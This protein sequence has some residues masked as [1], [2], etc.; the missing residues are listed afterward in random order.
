MGIRVVI[1]G[2]GVIGACLAYYLSQ[3][4][5]EVTL[6]ERHQIAAA[7][8]G[9]SGGFLALDWCDGSPLAPLARKSFKLHEELADRFGNRWGYR[10]LD[11]YSIAAAARRRLGS[12]TAVASLPWLKPGVILQSQLGT[13]E[14]TAQI[15]PAAFTRGMVERAVA[16][17]AACVIGNVKGVMLDRDGTRVRGVDIDDRELKPDVV[18][19]AMGPWSGLARRWLPVPDVYGLKGHSIL[20]RPSASVPAEAL[21]IDIEADDGVS[22]TPELFP[23]P[24]GTVYL[25]GLSSHDPLPENPSAVATDSA[26]SNRLRRMAGMLSSA[27][28]D[29][30]LLDT[31]ACYRPVTRDG[32][33]VLGAVPGIEGAYIATGHSVWG[34]LNAP[35]SGEAL[36][37]LILEGR[38]G[39]I[40]FTPF[41]PGRFSRKGSG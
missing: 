33:P 40:D 17:G 9:R 28:S 29:A 11:T 32:L 36:A 4:G 18:V 6:V 25:C 8:S 27:L 34:M 3:G 5:A 37:G 13:T 39:D 41:D 21:F 22:D 12:S 23:R 7:A 35:A 14:T 19:I 30:E 20:L 15:M 31:Q 38:T 1:C 16:Q 26:A 24:D 10:R 2:G